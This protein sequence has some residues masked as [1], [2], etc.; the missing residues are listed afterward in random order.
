MQIA[1][2]PDRILSG[3]KSVVQVPE[4]AKQVRVVEQRIRVLH[5]ILTRSL[6]LLKSIELDRLLGVLQRLLLSVGL[7][8][9]CDEVGK[10]FGELRPVRR[11][12][13]NCFPPE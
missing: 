11:V 8:K 3:C 2:A 13:A 7:R 12:P 10:R 1:V 4:L 6:G 9:M 5:R